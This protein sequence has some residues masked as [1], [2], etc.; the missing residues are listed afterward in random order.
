LVIQPDLIADVT[1]YPSE[2]SPRRGPMWGEFFSCPCKL[3]M[4]AP[5]AWDCRILLGNERIALGETKRVGI[6]FLS[7]EKAASMF[8]AAGRFYL[9]E[10]GIIGEAKVVSN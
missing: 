4:D 10:L 8:R 7:G 1:L 2:R 5:D 3:E 9:W 6:A